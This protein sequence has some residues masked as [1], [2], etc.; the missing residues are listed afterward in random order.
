MRTLLSGGTNADLG[1]PPS[2]AH[3]RLRD[4]VE[5]LSHHRS[6]G[7]DVATLVRQCLRRESRISHH[8]PVVR[9]PLGGAWP[10]SEDWEACSCTATRDGP[11]AVRVRA[12]AWHPDWLETGDDGFDDISVAAGWPAAARRPDAEV[13]ADPFF[14]NLLGPQYETYRTPGQRQAVRAAVTMADSATLIVN[15]PTGSG[16]TEVAIVLALAKRDARAISLLIVPTISLAHDLER[17]IQPI[18]CATG[19]ADVPVAHTGDTPADVKAAMYRRIREGTQPV[20][21]TSPESAL[22]SLRQPLLD[23]ATSGHV[24]SFVIDEAHLVRQWGT[25]F[26]PEFQALAGLRD[27]M[28]EAAP[29]SFRTLLLSAT[30]S[31]PDLD[32]LVR[33]FGAPGPTELVAANALRPEPEYWYAGSPD[34]MTREARTVE[35]LLHLPKPALLY[36]TKPADAERWRTLLQQEGLR[37]VAVVTGP[38]A[39]A[40]RAD[41]LAG[42]RGDS[43][44][45]R[46]DVV[47]ANSAF[48][49]G[50]SYDAIRTVIH[51]CLPETIDR[52]YQEVGRGGRDGYAALSL[53]SWTPSDRQ[54]QRAL[55]TTTVIG[56]EK[57][58]ARWNAMRAAAERLENGGMVVDLDVY[59]PYLRDTSDLNVAWNLASLALMRRAGMVDIVLPTSERRIASEEGSASMGSPMSDRL[60]TRSLV[61]HIRSGELRSDAAWQLAWAS[62]RTAI[63][64]EDAQQLAAME[65]ALSPGVRLCNLLSSVYVAAADHGLGSSVSYL[66]PVLACG[67]CQTCRGETLTI[68]VT[69]EP[70]AGR[71]AQGA[72]SER[73]RSAIGGST[74]VTV[75]FDPSRSDREV[76]VRRFIS[77]VASHGVQSFVMPDRWRDLPEFHGES[78]GSAFGLL[79]VSALESEPVLLPPVPTAVVVDLDGT[80]LRSSWYVPQRQPLVLVLAPTTTRHP[81]NPQWMLGDVPP[82]DDGASFDLE[83]FLHQLS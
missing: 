22:Q 65:Q 72:I 75:L 43:E 8:S 39:A 73:L 38:T 74:A 42:L 34:R 31:D 21:V 63:E 79:L 77:T 11:E 44:A 52:Y 6:G 32:L 64:Q 1:D 30:I 27:R 69:P 35:A 28:L 40:E 29:R 9:V 19:R 49:L 61:V 3:R 5:G 82:T 18:L 12:D 4:A 23:A 50:I 24:R 53:V 56:W 16:K 36:V 15:L 62:L 17:R 59:P 58:R 78:F 68:P 14:A 26:R 70:I 46:Y 20:V 54:V 25:S 48:G 41:V 71:H 57:A 76:L 10:G 60:W 13:T 80:G 67:R 55:A 45:T 51:A 81:T 66:Q 7:L 83:E 2:D 47:V 33:L 37:R